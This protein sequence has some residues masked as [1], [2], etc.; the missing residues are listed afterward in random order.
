MS[1]YWQRIVSISNRKWRR[2]CFTST[3]NYYFFFITSLFIWFFSEIFFWYRRC[4]GKT[5]SPIREPV[6]SCRQRCSA[7]GLSRSHWSMWTSL[8]KGE[9]CVSVPLYGAHIAELKQ[10]HWMNPGNLNKSRFD[11]C[12]LMK[13]DKFW[14]LLKLHF[15]SFRPLI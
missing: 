15:G 11:I 3:I 6:S 2:N 9:P 12:I 14:N 13:R 10:D 7:D 5:R 1:S 4:T 8:S